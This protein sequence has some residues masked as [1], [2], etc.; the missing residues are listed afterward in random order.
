MAALEQAQ[1]LP[2][3]EEESQYSSTV[4]ALR[5]DLPMTIAPGIKRVVAANGGAAPWG[6][7]S[8][9]PGTTSQSNQQS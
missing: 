2:E 1:M 9:S 7:R 4:R 8:P 5:V 6:H 3:E